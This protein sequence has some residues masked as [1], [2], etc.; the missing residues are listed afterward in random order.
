MA[1]L[2]LSPGMEL[3]LSYSDGAAGNKNKKSFES[4][5]LAVVSIRIIV[6]K[7]AAA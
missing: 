3:S 4:K 2:A 5:S 1:S 7:S 6:A